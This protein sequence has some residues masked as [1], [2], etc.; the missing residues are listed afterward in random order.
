MESTNYVGTPDRV[1]EK[2]KKLRDEHN[3]QYYTAHFS[4]GDIGHEKIMRS[5]ELFAKEV[6]PKFK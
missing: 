3:V 5:M 1:L 2:I 4:Y 6:M